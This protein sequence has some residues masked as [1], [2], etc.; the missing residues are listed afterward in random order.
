MPY[1]EDFTEQVRGYDSVREYILIGE[2]DGGCCGNEWKTWGYSFIN[3]KIPPHEL[4]GFSRHNL[5]DL[6]KHQICRTDELG[7]YFHSKTVSF[8]RK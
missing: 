1:R 3:E 8:R 7:N 6:S 5:D 2:T 4:N